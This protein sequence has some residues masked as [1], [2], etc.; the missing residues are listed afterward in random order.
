MSETNQSDTIRTEPT[1]SRPDSMPLFSVVI[2][3]FNRPTLLADALASLS[4]QTFDNFEAL[5]IND[6]GSPVESLL[7]GFSYPI[8]YV[9]QAQNR[10]PGA[11][12]NTAHRL[13]RGQYIVYLDDD[14]IFRPEHLETLAHAIERYPDEVIYSDA[15][16]IIEE[17]V[18]GKRVELRREQFYTHGE[19]SKDH[20]L[21][22]NYIP[23]NTFA[24]PRRLLDFFNGFDESLEGLEDWE[25]LLHLARHSVFRHIPRETVEVHMRSAK[26]DANRRSE[27]VKKNYPSLY[28]QVYDRHPSTNNEAVLR[29]RAAMLHHLDTSANRGQFRNNWLER[30]ALTLVQ[31]E[32]IK[33]QLI[34]QTSTPIFVV[35]VIDQDGNPA[36]LAATL[37]SLNTAK[38]I[39][40]HLF[41][42]IL[43]TSVDAA[44]QF[45]DEVVHIAR[46][47]WVEALNQVVAQ[48]SFDWIGLIHAGDELIA[49]G[50]LLS[51]LE[52]LEAPDC[53]ALY[54]DLS[55]CQDDGSYGL[56]LRP[57]FNLDYLLSLPSVM[58]RHWLFQRDTL[59]KAGGFHPQ[60]IENPEFELVL[61]LIDAEGL[62][63]LGHIAEVLLKTES[64]PIRELPE[65][66]QAILRHLSSRGYEDAQAKFEHSGQ[67]R[68]HYGH[69]SRPLV[70]ILVLAGDKLSTV[71][72]CIDSLLEKTRYSHYELLLIN[73]EPEAHD[74]TTW[75]SALES[76]GETG[77]QII[78]PPKP[79]SAAQ[80]LDY[81]VS[82]AKGS[83]YLLLSSQ[84]AVIQ[85]D[86]LDELLNHAQRPEVGAVGAKLVSPEGKIVQAGLILG[87]NGVAG[88]AFAGEHMHA[89][90]YLQRLQVDQN[91]S[92]V[93][94]DCLMI[95]REALAAVQ[96]FSPDLTTR[97]FDV[98]LC[99][100]LRAAGY[101]NVWA[102]N[103]LLL[104]T[105]QPSPQDLS[106]DEAMYQK[107]LPVLARDPAHNANLALSISG[108]FS[109]ADST[110]SWRPLS[111]WRPLPIVFACV[112]KHS[113]DS[114]YRIEKPLLAMTS[115][116]LIEGISSSTFLQPCE[117]ERLEPDSIVVQ[118]DPNDALPRP[119]HE[120]K[121]H[122]N[123][124]KIL[125]LGECPSDW[126][127][128]PEHT[129]QVLART[130]QQQLAFADRILVPTALFAEAI[131]NTQAEIVVAPNYLPSHLWGNLVS[132]R[133]A[134]HRPRIGWAGSAHTAADLRMLTDVIKELAEDVEWIIFGAC[135]PEL[136][137]HV[138]EIH[139]KINPEQDPQRLARL[140]LDLALAPLLDT[141]FNRCR[142]N[143]KILEYGACGY[144]V[145][146]SKFDTTNDNLPVTSANNNTEDW[147]KAI[148]MHLND[149]EASA[150]LG[151][152]LQDI[153][154]KDWLLQGAA[155]EA[156]KM[157]WLP[158]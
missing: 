62:K 59:I 138:H 45:P 92:A 118:V 30:R 36:K 39:Y 28:R 11:G 95:S 64:P 137:G 74:V 147:I 128:N 122:S 46:D 63:G 158:S 7:T 19:Y 9:R 102:A 57:D 26:V 107:W 16:F 6:N 60:F 55:Y 131:G 127:S 157:A 81:A 108:G 68:I 121:M 82:Q 119:L 65:E 42:I 113:V 53:R 73:N 139:E 1:P 72:H 100:R 33:T 41:P 140:N 58:G 98:D 8:T 116:G 13:A 94:K 146:R 97:H 125:D 105:S 67:Y 32:L 106:D 134:G 87:L 22:R 124:F 156:W 61:R 38:A 126:L 136:H 130:V 76:L 112:S 20:L 52:L 150:Q 15:I 114:H 145:I 56:A 24:F 123:A 79:V 141:P 44:E 155:L 88:P 70:S 89:P 115:N 151:H 12:R 148:R 110:L 78:N 47:H 109:L 77:L 154:R 143:L 2:T 75:L 149:K 101:L 142:S 99:L 144:P 29:G 71:Q 104:S 129:P 120:I 10:G 91:Y 34:A 27:L 152:Y 132:I 3:T 85:E 4:R 103:A 17:I 31:R 93:S 83:Y 133:S 14:D 5:L 117:L 49:N 86:W 54:Y 25:F 40:P 35:A 23:V 96:G 80:A 111:S 66:K 69:N 43:S 21:I 51:A 18:E 50:L 48:T 90:G 153:V 135:P 37:R 84:A